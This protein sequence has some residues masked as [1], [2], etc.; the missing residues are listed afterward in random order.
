MEKLNASVGQL[1]SELGFDFFNLEC[2]EELFF[3]E[4][5]VVLLEVF[6]SLLF[7]EVSQ[8][9]LDR[10]EHLRNGPLCEYVGILEW[11]PLTAGLCTAVLTDVLV[12]H[13][14]VEFQ[15]VFVGQ[16]VVD[17]ASFGLDYVGLV[18]GGHVG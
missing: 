10:K 14:V 6:F 5:L 11:G 17:F 12:H 9:S 7:D 16:R 8:L 4:F 13:V 18:R 3:V 1:P 2:L 15:G